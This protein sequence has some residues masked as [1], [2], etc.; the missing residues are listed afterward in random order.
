MKYK[1]RRMTGMKLPL[2]VRVLGPGTRVAIRSDLKKD[3]T[4]CEFGVVW[5]AGPRPGTRWVI[6][7][8]P[9]GEPSSDVRVYNI[10]YL[11]SHTN[12]SRWKIK[13]PKQ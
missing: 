7:D 2:K 11:K 1:Q 12:F 3:W 10:A 5:S 4:N 8:R 6:V 13:D 9:D